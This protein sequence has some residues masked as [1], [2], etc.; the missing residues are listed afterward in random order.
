VAAGSAA[1]ASA[2]DVVPVVSIAVI[3][4]LSMLLM[5]EGVYV[6][7]L[8]VATVMTIENLDLYGML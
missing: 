6:W 1:A 4:L 3:C 8:H 2:P 5:I 7:M